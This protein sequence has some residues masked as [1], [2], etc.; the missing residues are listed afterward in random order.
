MQSYQDRTEVTVTVDYPTDAGAVIT[1]NSITYTV[2]DEDGDTLAAET[3]T[4]PE[5]DLG[6]QLTV[7]IPST[8]NHV[9]DSALRA[10]RLVTFEFGADSGTYTVQHRYAIEKAVLLVPMKNSFQTYERALLTRM[11]LVNADGWDSADV[12]AQF[13]SLVEAHARMCRL[14]YKYRMNQNAV[15]YDAS[16]PYWVVD[17]MAQRT[18]DDLRSWPDDFVS[19]L[20]KAQVLEANYILTGDPIVQRRREG[21]ISETIGEVKMFFQSTPPLRTPINSAAMT[22]ISPFL[23]KSRR[24]GRG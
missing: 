12:P 14:T 5:G 6:S 13:A 24:I 21:V 11:D 16:D 3:V 17:S 7:V 9:P 1:P 20:R 23:Y 19:A 4:P 10:A 18:V 22:V 15:M 8:L 2:T